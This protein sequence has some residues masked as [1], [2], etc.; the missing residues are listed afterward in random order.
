MQADLGELI[1]EHLKEHGKQVVDRSS[2]TLANSFK[3]SSY[4]ENLLLF[5]KD[6][7]QTADLGSESGSDMLGAVRN[8]ILNATHDV[9]QK[10]VPVHK[11]TETRN[12]TRD[13]RPHLGLV[14]LKQLDE[15]G[16][17]IS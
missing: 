2:K 11:G 16:N 13:R 15:R 10:G 5:A 12:L 8:K 9:V 4:A 17:Q 7:G 1:L 3:S 14:I 6:R